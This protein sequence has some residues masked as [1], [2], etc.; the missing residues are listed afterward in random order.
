[1]SRP[2]R[3]LWPAL[4][5]IFGSC[6][7]PPRAWSILE[8]CSGLPATDRLAL[9]RKRSQDEQRQIRIVKEMDDPRAAAL[10]ASVQAPATFRTPPVRG[11]K[12]PAV[13]FAAK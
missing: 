1:P 12:S 8:G 4:L 13:G 6:T 2:L 10:S 9:L 3:M 5:M 7:S 11:I